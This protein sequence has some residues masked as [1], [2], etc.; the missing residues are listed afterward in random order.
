[1][2]SSTAEDARMRPWVL[3]RAEPMHATAGRL[4][5][6][7]GLQGGADALAALHVATCSHIAWM[8]VWE[9]KNRLAY[10]RVSRRA[11]GCR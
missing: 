1:M 5:S 3:A 4:P 6:G 11:N 8:D 9:L 2:C 10:I 7:A